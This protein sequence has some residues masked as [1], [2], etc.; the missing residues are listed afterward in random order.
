[1]ENL[2]LAGR[3][4]EWREAAGHRPRLLDRCIGPGL[5][6]LERPWRQDGHV[7][8]WQALSNQFFSQV[9]EKSR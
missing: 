4:I 1:L 2:N 8:A 7:S 3:N 5:S 6:R 9:V